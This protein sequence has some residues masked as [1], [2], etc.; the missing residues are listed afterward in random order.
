[1]VT[2]DS[3]VVVDEHSNERWDHCRTDQYVSNIGM[4][5]GA[6][7]F[8]AYDLRTGERR[9]SELAWCHLRS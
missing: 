9:G 2:T 4:G 8:V 6:S 1:M 5:K 3:L 7:E